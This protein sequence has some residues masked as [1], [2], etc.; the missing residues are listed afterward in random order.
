MGFPAKPRLHRAGRLPALSLI[1]LLLVFARGVEA[2]SLGSPV[3][4]GKGGGLSRYNFSYDLVQQDIRSDNPAFGGSSTSERVLVEG[5][6]SLDPFIDLS[7]HLGL[8]D[9]E[10]SSRG[11]N[12]AFG[13]AIGASARWAFY[14]KGDVRL[15]F[16]IQALEF[17]TRDSDSTSPRLIWSELASFVGGEIQGLER[18]LPYFGVSF[19]K[20]F[21]DLRNGPTIRTDKFFGLYVGAEFFVYKDYYFLSEARIINENSLTFKVSYH[22]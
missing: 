9:F 16:G 21:G 22:L 3:P 6:Y 19:I 13:P 20:G 2:G 11:F 8:A 17:L 15:G 18:I 4:S 7:F 5:V 10:N 12:G 1:L 14:Q